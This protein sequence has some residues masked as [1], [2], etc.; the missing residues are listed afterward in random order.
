MNRLILLS[1]LFMLS[2]S[3]FGDLF[4]IHP[5]TTLA[6]IGNGD[7]P[8]SAR[9]LLKRM[10][11][12]AK[13]IDFDSYTF[14]QLTIRFNQDGSV[15]DT[16][17]WHEALRF[18]DQFRI[19]FGPLEK[20]TAVIYRNDSMYFFKEGELMRSGPEYNELL[21]MEGGIAVYELDTVLARMERYGYDLD[22]FY[23]TE[24]EG[25]PVYVI[26]AEEGDVK[27]KQIW[28]HQEKL[29]T[30]RRIDPRPD[31]QVM[32]IVFD[33]FV[34]QGGA[35]IETWVEFYL[36]GKL[37]QT[38]RYQDI[39]TEIEVKEILFDPAHFGEWHWTN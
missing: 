23:A 20:E 28:I 33:D 26:G 11:K 2:F 13:S 32:E 8:K 14:V 15:R 30:L 22:K 25:E 10:K 31:G 29:A 4:G 6:G 24:F 27:S 1:G 21:L 18:P 9:A 38:E 17:I 7:E 12:D 36:D 39:D 35:W 34:Y 5:K 3:F 16:M 19:D 37:L